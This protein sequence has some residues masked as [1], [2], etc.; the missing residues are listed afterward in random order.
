MKKI[1]WL[2]EKLHTPTWLFILLIVV[3]IFRIPSFFEPYSYGDE[4]IYLTLGE[5]IRQGIP[6]YSGIHDNKPPL[7]Y[8]MAGVAGNLF[9][10][11][12]IL[13]FWVIL[14]IYVFWKLLDFLFPKNPKAQKVG[15]FIFALLTTIPLLEGNIANAE[16]FMIGPTILAFLILLSKKLSAKNLFFS[17]VLFSTSTLFKVPAFFDIGTILFMWITGIKVIKLQ[18]LQRIAKNIL[19]LFL[20]FAAPITLTLIW[21]F[22]QGA[23]K[24]YVI[25]AFLQ[26]VGYLSS[27][28]P[29]DVRDPFLIR[30]LP[31]IIR[32][33]VVL[34]GLLILYWK[35]SRLSKNFIFATSWLLFTLFAATLSE[36][37]YPHYLVQGIAPFS[38]LMTM[39]F[40]GKNIEQVLVIIPLTLSLFVPFY[41]HFWH[42]PTLPYYEKFIKLATGK[43]SKDQYFTTF[44]SNVNRN[45]KISEFIVSSTKK[46]EKVFVW[47]SDSSSV[48]ALTKRFP[49][50]KYVADYHIKD[51]STDEETIS[52]L[53]SDLPSYIVLLPSSS[54][55]SGMLNLLNSNYGLV[56]TIDQAEIWKL[57]AP[58]IRTYLSI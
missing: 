53:K 49:P 38:I 56:E 11:K 51:F 42:Y 24:E 50:G 29:D 48:Y 4:T 1:N 34:S 23:L 45:Y 13:T 17:G 18:S 15:V 6:L 30:N 8:S 16:L 43:Y 12:A 39:L 21:Y 26:N 9:W 25:A 2:S 3:F 52:I 47:G 41:Y 58:E 57:L 46:G 10:F 44:G 22:S 55:I 36:R 20:G 32:G 27:W 33:S 31:L 5:A 54:E 35:R 40:T 7:L 14:T 37:P 28:R 19:F